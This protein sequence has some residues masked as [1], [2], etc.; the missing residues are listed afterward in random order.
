MRLYGL[1]EQ[2]TKII[3]VNGKNIEITP[4]PQTGSKRPN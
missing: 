4:D 1:L 2:L 3:L